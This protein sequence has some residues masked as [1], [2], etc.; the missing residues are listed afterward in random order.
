LIIIDTE[1]GTWFEK[2]DLRV[3]NG[4]VDGNGLMVVV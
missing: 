1:I 4:E 2:M 3:V